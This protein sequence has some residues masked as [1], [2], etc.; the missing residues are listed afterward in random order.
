MER[1]LIVDLLFILDVVGLEIR[2]SDVL[3]GNYQKQAG[4]WD[5]NG[6]ACGRAMG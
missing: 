1:M 3:R 4:I 2:V 6:K 5:G